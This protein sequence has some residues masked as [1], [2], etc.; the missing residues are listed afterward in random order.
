MEPTVLTI[1]QEQVK[2]AV[3]LYLG[4]HNNGGFDEGHVES[5]PVRV[6]EAWD[7]YVRGYKVDPAS[8]LRVQ[9]TGGTYDEMI[10]VRNVRVVSVC[11]HHFAPIIGKAHFAYVPDR[12]IVGLSKIPRMIRALANRF[13]VQ[14]NL[15]EQIVDTFQAYVKPRGCAVSV[16]AYHLCML[17]RGVEEVASYTET[18]ALRGVFKERTDTRQ[19]FLSSIDRNE[20]IFP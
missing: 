5:T 7:Q 3:E 9:F 6:A 20:A 14:E 15:T 11:A 4:A 18:T 8:V 10:H 19:E 17:M 1:W 16:R 13:Q 2:H 12:R